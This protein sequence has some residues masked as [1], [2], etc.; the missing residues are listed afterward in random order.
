[1]APALGDEGLA[2]LKARFEELAAT[3]AKSKVDDRKVIGI[4]TRGPVPRGF[5]GA[6]QSSPHPVCPD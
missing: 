5:R 4:S 2:M 6:L 1:M 3:P